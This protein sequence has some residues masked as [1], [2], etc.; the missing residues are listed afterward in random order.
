M[1]SIL[2]TAPCDRL[3]VVVPTDALRTQIADKFLSLGILKNDGLNILK[4]GVER[5]VVCSLQHIPTTVAEVDDLLTKAQVFVTTSAI[6][7]QCSQEVRSRMAESVPYLF[8][9]EAH[10]AEAPTWKTFKGAFASSRVVQF[11]AT[12]FREDD[13]PLDG[14]MVFRYSVK[15]AQIDGYFKPINF[16]PITDFDQASGDKR[17]LERL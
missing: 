15:Q 14:R 12:P 3:L 2:L 9:D 1:L 6:A 7:G 11:T 17:S 8:I 16:E 13:K 5:P 10:H 4:P